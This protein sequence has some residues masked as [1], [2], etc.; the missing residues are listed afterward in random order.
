MNTGS[1]FTSDTAVQLLIMTNT[2][3]IEAS[4]PG[5]LVEKVDREVRLRTV[6][7][8][9]VVVEEL[10]LGQQ[11]E[12]GQQMWRTNKHPQE[13]TRVSNDLQPPARLTCAGLRPRPTLYQRKDNRDKERPGEG[14]AMETSTDDDLGRE[15]RLK[16]NFTSCPLA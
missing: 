13:E 11:A 6:S 10:L 9:L 14:G 1:Y 16:A 5:W 4:M 12:V 7:P 2:L 8:Y 15:D 3:N